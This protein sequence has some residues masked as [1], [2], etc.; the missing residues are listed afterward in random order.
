MRFWKLLLPTPPLTQTFALSK[1][2]V[3]TLGYERGRWVGR[4]QRVGPC[5]LSMRFW[6]SAPIYP[7]PNLNFCPKLEVSVNVRLREG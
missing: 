2:L 5:C 3:L 4:P 1:T 6:D 7:S